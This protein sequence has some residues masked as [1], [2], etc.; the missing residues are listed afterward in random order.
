MSANF[1]C[2]LT[3]HKDKLTAIDWLA[4][5]PETQ[6]LS[7]QNLKAAMQ[8]GAVWLSVSENDKK[9]QRLRRAKR[10]LKPG[11]CLHLYYNS[12][13]LNQE[14]TPPE[15][16]EDCGDYSVWHKPNGMLSQGSKWGDHT[17][18][19]RWV[20]QHYHPNNETKPAF[21][22]HRLDKATHGLMLL[23]HSQTM[24]KQL[25][26]LFEVRKI[27]KIYQAWVWGEFPETQ[28]DFNTQIEGR[29]AI[30]HAKRLQFDADKQRSLVEVSIET[31]RKHQIRIHLSQ[32]GFPIIGDR[33][34]GN[35]HHYT[36]DLQLTAMS[37]CLKGDTPHLQKCFYL[38]HSP[39]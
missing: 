19:H 11:N 20:E 3:I 23:A 24:A 5:L 21:V 2:H 30:S 22:V 1:E 4:S 6:T 15:L 12:D 36:E 17:T 32:A 8:K 18:L 39:P 14:I 10:I 7:K 33:L 35:E 13:V 27:A 38:R 25:S 34:Y 9:P 29:K 37:L 26:Q 31:G 28:Q 16:I